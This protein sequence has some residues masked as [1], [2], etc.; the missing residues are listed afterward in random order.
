M[1]RCLNPLLSLDPNAA[2]P[3]L[4]HKSEEFLVLSVFLKDCYPL[5]SDCLDL[6]VQSGQIT[7]SSEKNLHK[8][9]SL[10]SFF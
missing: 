6:A 1:A 2:V 7:P 5:G 3:V 10:V 9:L 4:N 8:I